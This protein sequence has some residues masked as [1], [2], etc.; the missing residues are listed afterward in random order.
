MRVP[1]PIRLLPA[2]AFQAWLTPPPLG[3]RTAQRDTDAV[4][5]IPRAV[6][7]GV[8]GFDLGDGPLVLAIHGW[9][10]RA[11]QFAP[12]ARR[13][14]G[15]GY[16]VVA[17]DLPGRAGSP[18]TDIKEVAAS[19]RRVIDDVGEPDVLVAHSFGA[20]AL[21]LVFVDE[22]PPAVV[23]VAP[24]LRVTDALDVFGERLRLLPWTRRGLQSRLVEWD[25]ELWPTVSGT[26][27][28]QL[29]G[30]NVLVV[31]GP[32]DVDTPFAR[33]AELAAL[34]PGTEI[35]VV[36]A[37]HNDV[38]VDPEALGRIVEFVER[39]RNRSHTGRTG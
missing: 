25:P 4:E 24:A 17:V 27:P 8:D 21:R 20:I 39:H 33:S 6:I 5:G 19:I 29:P 35:V 26:L 10:G 34:R 32:D 38:L 28:E 14:A 15:A 30:A 12:M 3:R 7:G 16:R 13:L 22:A 31:H 2:M 37:G 11:A 9:G 23:L 18:K 1:L 36:G